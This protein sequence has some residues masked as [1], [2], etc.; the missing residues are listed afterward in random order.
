MGD[1][2]RAS[3]VSFARV[4]FGNFLFLGFQVCLL[5]AVLF[6]DSFGATYGSSLQVLSISLFLDFFVTYVLVTLF[7]ED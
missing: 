6:T 7:L 5:C 2:S 3:R 4:M 1:H